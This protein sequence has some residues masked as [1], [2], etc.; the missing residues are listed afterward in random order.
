MFSHGIIHEIIR[1]VVNEES[2]FRLPEYP[3]L[4]SLRTAYGIS[5]EVGV[6][7]LADVALD[8]CVAVQ[9]KHPIVLCE[10]LAKYRK[11]VVGFRSYVG[12][13]RVLYAVVELRHIHRSDRAV[14][15]QPFQSAEQ[16]NAVLRKLAVKYH[17][18]VK[19]GFI[20]VAE[21]RIQTH[22]KWAGVFFVAGAADIHRS[23]SG[24]KARETLNK[25]NSPRSNAHTH[26][27]EFDTLRFIQRV[28]MHFLSSKCGLL[29]CCHF[30]LRI[31]FIV[32]YDRAVVNYFIGFFGYQEL[33]VMR[34][35]AV[36]NKN[37]GAYAPGSSFIPRSG[38]FQAAF[39]KFRIPAQRRPPSLKQAP[40]GA[41]SRPE[42]T[43]PAR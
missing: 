18:V 23:E 8:Y 28:P 41:L 2:L 25:S 35:F 22:R 7:K 24:R 21:Q 40:Y 1:I 11:A 5:A 31:T 9:I 37:P 42:W 32:L 34:S 29:L 6:E 10:N 36:K 30:M 16:F 26:A 19:P 14:L 12:I 43:V 39:L 3:D 4:D 20:S 38:L 17:N 33:S 27:A 15:E 13:G